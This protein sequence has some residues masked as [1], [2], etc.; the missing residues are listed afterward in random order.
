MDKYLILKK[1]KT[2]IHSLTF[3]CVVKT[4]ERILHDSPKTYTFLRHDDFIFLLTHR[5]SNAFLLFH[6]SLYH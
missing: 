4:K 5:P 2:H 6:L 3:L 1:K